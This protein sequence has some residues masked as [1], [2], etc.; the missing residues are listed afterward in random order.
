MIDKE[1][2]F[3]AQSSVPGKA[4]TCTEPGA[5]V[6]VPNTWDGILPV[7]HALQASLVH[8]ENALLGD[9]ASSNF[10]PLTNGTV[11]EEGTLELPP[12]RRVRSL[13]C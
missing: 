7:I 2:S 4:G 3:P 1:S 5:A 6:L 8:H 9:A 13:I 10:T 12:G 11:P